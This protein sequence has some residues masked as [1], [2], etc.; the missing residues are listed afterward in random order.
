MKRILFFTCILSSIYTHAQFAVFENNFNVDGTQG[1]TLSDQDGDGSNWNIKNNEYNTI[2]G[3][4][5][6]GFGEEYLVLSSL[7]VASTYDN[8]AILPVQDLSFYTGTKLEFTYLRGIFECE[9][10]D[11]VMVYA[12]TSPV[13]ADMLL[14]EPIATVTLEGDNTTIDPPVKVTKTIDIPSVYNVADIY[15][16]IVHKKPTD[17]ESNNYIVELSQVSITAQDIL[18]TEPIAAKTATRIKQNPVTETL[19]LQLGS[20]VNADALH[21]QLYNVS[22][23]L[24]KEAKYSEAGVAVGNLA[25]GMYF[26]VINDGAATERLK[27]IK[28]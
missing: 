19:Q 11:Y 5:G 13:I 28:K 23:M 17:Q 9:Q 2:G 25:S 22:G 20:A 18:G 7:R 3:G 14:G 12:S 1:W 26:V 6:S 8:W 16:A 27:F 24:V 10:T 21:L 4:P 15:F